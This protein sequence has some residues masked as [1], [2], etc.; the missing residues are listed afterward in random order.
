MDCKQA[1][2]MESERDGRYMNSLGWRMMSA[3]PMFAGYEA[4]EREVPRACVV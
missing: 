4:I 1:P 2:Q 3:D